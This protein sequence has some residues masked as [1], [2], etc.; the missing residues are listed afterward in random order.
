MIKTIIVWHDCDPCVTKSLINYLNWKYL[1]VYP[2]TSIDIAYIEDLRGENIEESK[3]LTTVKECDALIYSCQSYHDIEASKEV[4][5]VIKDK[6][7]YAVSCEDGN[8]TERPLGFSL[9]SI[10]NVTFVNRESL[11]KLMQDVR[12]KRSRL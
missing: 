3:L 12:K 10:Q 7:W 5:E 1:T 9:F 8:Q 2:N 11:V 6:H 4:R